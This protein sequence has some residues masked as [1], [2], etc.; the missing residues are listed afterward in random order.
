MVPISE[1]MVYLQLPDGRLMGVHG[2]TRDGHAVARYSTDQ[3]MSWGGVEPLFPLDPSV[4]SWSL[5]NALL[6]HDGEIQ[7]VFT[8][9]ANTIREGKGLYEIHFDIWHVR[10]RDG[11]TKWNPPVEVWNGY[12]GSLLSFKQLHNGRVLLPFCFLTSRTWANRGEGFQKFTYMGRFSSSTAYSDDNGQTWHISPDILSEPTPDLSADGGIEPAVLQL[13]DGSIRMLIRTQDN[14]FYESLSADGSRW[15]HPVPTSILSS[16]SP[17][18]LTRLH[19]GRVVMLW[20]NTQR[21]PYANGGRAVLHGAISNDDGKTWS[22]YREVAAN[23]LVVEPPPPNGDH[24]VTY[25]VP[26]LTKEGNLVTS[27]STGPGGGEYLLRVDPEWLCE[28]SQSLDFSKGLG[29]VST[30]G[31]RGVSLVTDPRN[32]SR[33]VLAITHPDPGWPAGAVWNFPSGHR[34]DLRLDLLIRP[35]FGGG[36]LGLTDQFSSPFDEQD[37]FFNLFNLEIGASGLV[38]K[39]THLATGQWNQLRLQ[40]DCGTGQC[41]VSVNG[42]AIAALPLLRHETPGPSYLRLRSA[43]RLPDTSG[44][45]IASAAV[46]VS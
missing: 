17:C 44:M 29:T 23:P 4:G 25:T 28:T 39:D 10:S 5:H 7:L 42:K 27:L 9:D 14:R 2:A 33:Q 8:N 32:A 46:N 24:G 38:Q 15:S 31:T 40:W 34:G 16:D 21:F 22:G 36:V 37:I 18:S 41:S 3:A 45:M 6:D 43:S 20:N 1:Y 26:T 19:D 11:R 35:S 30:Y 13:K 12:A